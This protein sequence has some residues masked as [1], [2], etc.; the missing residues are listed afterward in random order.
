MMQSGDSISGRTSPMLSPRLKPWYGFYQ[1]MVYTKH[2]VIQVATNSVNDFIMRSAGLR[3]E[4]DH[5]HIDHIVC[6]DQDN[7][8]VNSMGLI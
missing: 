3:R 5:P 6:S 1:L 2:C 4:E 7:N 8:P